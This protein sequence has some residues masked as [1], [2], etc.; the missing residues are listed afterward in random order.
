M[1]G[2]ILVCLLVVL[3]LGPLLVILTVGYL[4]TEAERAKQAQE[5]EQQVAQEPGFFARPGVE[6]PVGAP[7]TV[8]DAIVAE[9]QTY[10][11]TEQ[12]MVDEFVSRPS[13]EGLHRSSKKLAVRK[14]MLN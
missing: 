11:A 1:S 13:L 2:A 14:A 9:I 12:A 5:A 3:M 7:Q 8:G 4:N 6:A 10:L